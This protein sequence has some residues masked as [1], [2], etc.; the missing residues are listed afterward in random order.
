M[1]YRNIILVIAVILLLPQIS[2][3]RTSSHYYLIKDPDL[4]T[5]NKIDQFE[6]FDYSLLFSEKYSVFNIGY[7]GENFRRIRIKFISVIK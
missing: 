1:K 6:H 2:I 3:G 5:E 7:I 4:S